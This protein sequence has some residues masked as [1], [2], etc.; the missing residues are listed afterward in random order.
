MDAMTIKRPRPIKHAVTIIPTCTNLKYKFEILTWMMK[1]T[2]SLSL[3]KIFSK[4]TWNSL[5]KLKKIQKKMNTCCLLLRGPAWCRWSRR[6]KTWW[7]TCRST[8]VFF[9]DSEQS[10]IKILLEILYNYDWISETFKFQK[11]EMNW[12]CG[13]KKMNRHVS[14]WIDDRRRPC[15]ISNPQQPWTYSNSPHGRR[16]Q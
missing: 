6:Y 7:S 15:L 3:E 9:L 5:R 12:V 8:S 13:C 4:I 10:S 16:N 2:N 11:I 14:T 1:F